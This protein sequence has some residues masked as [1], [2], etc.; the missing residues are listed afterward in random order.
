ML[1][2]VPHAIMSLVQLWFNS[3]DKRNW[4]K[5]KTHGYRSV[6]FEGTLCGGVDIFSQEGWRLTIGF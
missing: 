3:F 1:I 4:T 2:I 5:K 6:L